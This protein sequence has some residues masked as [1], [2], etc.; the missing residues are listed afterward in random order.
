MKMITDFLIWLHCRLLVVA[1]QV[2]NQPMFYFNPTL[3]I[4]VHAAHHGR[5]IFIQLNN[6]LS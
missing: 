5:T 3:H 4:A 2:P 6:L 1:T